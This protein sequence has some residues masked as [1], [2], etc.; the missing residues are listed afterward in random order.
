MNDLLTL[1]DIAETFKCDMRRA[2]NVIVLSG[3]FPAPAPASTPRKRRWLRHEVRAFI[4]RKTPEVLREKPR[5]NPA[6]SVSSK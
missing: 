1:E 4:N 5:K 3:G 2:R 6:K